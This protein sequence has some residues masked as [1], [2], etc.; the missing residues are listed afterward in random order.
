MP[1]LDCFIFIDTSVPE[2]ERTVEVLCVECHK[3]KMPNSGFFYEGS[4]EGYS[5]Y[6][7]QCVMCKKYVH[8][9]VEGFEECSEEQE[10]E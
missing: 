1:D 5:N 6:D 4:K 8:K 9:A 2:Q 7:W 3:E 10:S